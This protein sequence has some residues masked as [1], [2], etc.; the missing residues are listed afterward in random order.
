MHVIVTRMLSLSAGPGQRADPWHILCS[1]R[2]REKQQWPSTGA[3][4]LGG[5]V[6]NGDKSR[7]PRVGVFRNLKKLVTG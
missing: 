7:C 6:P 5:V 3:G 1:S 4:F 2:R